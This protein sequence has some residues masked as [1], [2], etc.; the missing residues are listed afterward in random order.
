M[1]RNFVLAR[2]TPRTNAARLGAR[3]DLSNRGSSRRTALLSR[4]HTSFYAVDGGVDPLGGVG[5]V[6]EPGRGDQHRPAGR[7]WIDD[8][9]RAFRNAGADDCR[10]EPSRGKWM[11]RAAGTLT[12]VPR[13]PPRRRFRP[14][15]PKFLAAAPPESS[16]VPCRAYAFRELKV[17]A[18]PHLMKEQQRES[19]ARSCRP[20]R[21]H[22]R[23]IRQRIGDGDV[24][25]GNRRSHQGF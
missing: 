23:R 8:A 19:I 9:E 24:T 17:C 2:C 25:R 11:P 22:R 1:N 10:G 5:R 21:L 4:C 18:S 6:V 20:R 16:N 12:S 3:V 13:R 14:T 15:P 7:H